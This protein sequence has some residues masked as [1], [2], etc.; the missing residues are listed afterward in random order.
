MC[1][2]RWVVTEQNFNVS[3]QVETTSMPSGSGI[4][5]PAVSV[6]QKEETVGSLLTVIP[7]VQ[8]DG[9]ILLS[10]AYDNTV[11]QPL[12]TI[13]FGDKANPL[14]LQQLTIDGNGT[15]QQLA[16]QPGQ[17]LVMS[18]FDRHLSET[19]ERRLTPGLA[20]TIT[21]G[22]GTGQ[23]TVVKDATTTYSAMSAESVCKRGDVNQFA[24]F[25]R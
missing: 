15:V 16:V 9:Q 20:D 3:D 8:E 10:I 14:Q 19:A 18:G 7:D 4:A 12:K 24:F 2:I 13:T 17:P 23:G 25:A 1:L 5:L 22:Q 6:N 11:A 21:V